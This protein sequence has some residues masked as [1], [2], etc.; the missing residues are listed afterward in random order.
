MNN[1]NFLKKTKSNEITFL[2]FQP[3]IENHPKHDT[4]LRRKTK[5]NNILQLKISQISIILTIE[6]W[7]H[8]LLFILAEDVLFKINN[9][10]PSI[11]QKELKLVIQTI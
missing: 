2:R 8:S 10:L 9:K 7:N 4:K 6:L 3:I 1:I 11:Q 5:T